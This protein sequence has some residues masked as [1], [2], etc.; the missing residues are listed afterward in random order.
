M[1]LPAIAYSFGGWAV[2]TVDNLP[3]YVVAGQP[4][5][6]S[7]VVRQHGITLLS[8]LRPRI[9]ATSG[10]LETSVDAH[11]AKEAGHYGGTLTLPRDGEWTVTVFSGF[12]RSNRTLPLLQAIPTGGRPPAAISDVDRGGRLFVAKGCV[13]CHV[14]AKVNS[15]SEI[16]MGPDLTER[17]YT[18]DFLTRFLANPSLVQPPKPGSPSMPVLDLKAREIA[19]LV[20]FINA[21]RQLTEK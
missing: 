19:S 14:N 21:D 1:L 20:A 11:A 9:V 8:G 12:G 10:K 15:V 3:E 13:T 17:R 18:A 7:F 5:S 2:V 4:L 16:A 6:L